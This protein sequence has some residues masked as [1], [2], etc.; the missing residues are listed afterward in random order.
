MKISGSEETSTALPFV[1]NSNPSSTSLGTTLLNVNTPS[2]G[3]APKSILKKKTESRSTNPSDTRTKVNNGANGCTTD[4]N[5]NAPKTF[6]DRKI[7][8][9]ANTDPDIIPDTKTELPADVAQ[10]IPEG[11]FDDPKLDAKVRNI[12]YKDKMDEQ[13]E[14]FQKAIKEEAMVSES[15]IEEDDEERDEQRLLDEI[16]EQMIMWSKVEYLAKSKQPQYSIISRYTIVTF[17]SNDK[18]ITLQLSSGIK[19]FVRPLT[20]FYFQS[21]AAVGNSCSKLL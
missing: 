3:S 17:D 21:K 4:D 2:S 18:K 6:K 5:L 13:M 15:I 8:T 9:S 11:F 19:L 14:L 12:P 7:E 10:F 16:D 1:S 20:K